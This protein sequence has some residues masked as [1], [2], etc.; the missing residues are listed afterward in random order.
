MKSVGLEINAVFA[1][2]A[3]VLVEI[4]EMGKRR[5]LVGFVVNGNGL[6]AK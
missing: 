1:A 4:V 6:V 5:G 3:I 2:N